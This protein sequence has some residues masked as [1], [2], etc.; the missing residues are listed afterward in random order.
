MAAPSRRPSCIRPRSGAIAASASCAA[1]RRGTWKLISS[2]TGGSTPNG[3][4]DVI[5]IYNAT[6]R[7]GVRFNL[8]FIGRDFDMELPAPFDQGF[9]RALFQYGYERG[10]RGYDWARRPPL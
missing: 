9:M 3:Y 6:Q 7:D 4:N 5:R 10:R 8:A 2:A 1:A